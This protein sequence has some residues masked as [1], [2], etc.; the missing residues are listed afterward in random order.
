[1][2]ARL[3]HV[4]GL[5]RFRDRTPASHSFAVLAHWTARTGEEEEVERVL[6]QLASA[7]RREAGCITYSAVRSVDHPS[8]YVIYECYVDEHAFERHVES[9]HFR[10]LALED[11]IPRLSSRTRESYT[12]IT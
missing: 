11:G 6:R 1:V 8:R 4:L 3:T 9:E 7:S 10:A 12:V 2:L 5:V